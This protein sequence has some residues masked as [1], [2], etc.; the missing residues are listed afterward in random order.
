MK[1]TQFAASLKR[2]ALS[3]AAQDWM[4]T[5]P[6]DDEADLAFTQFMYTTSMIDGDDI[7]DEIWSDAPETVMVRING[8]T[9]I[10]IDV[11]SGSYMRGTAD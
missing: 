11:G 5:E 9:L 1:I 3:A 7:V 10:E 8:G 4:K 6:N 2:A